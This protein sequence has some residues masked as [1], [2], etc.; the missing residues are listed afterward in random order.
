[1]PITAPTN[2]RDRRVAIAY[3]SLLGT[4][5][6]YALWLSQ[7]VHADC[8]TYRQATAKRLTAYDTVVVLSGTY[9]GH[10]P[11][12]GFLKKHWSAMLN[13][14]VIVV[15]VG[16]LP[17]DSPDS[18]ASYEHIP[19]NIRQHIVYIKIPGK[20]GK[21]ENPLKPVAPENLRPVIDAISQG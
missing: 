16:V 2:T 19:E 11:L 18:I 21:E 8:L 17:P 12:V 3:H 9:V 20:I 15:A 4:T 13:K 14:R 10:M 6:K 5:K 7:I 1:M